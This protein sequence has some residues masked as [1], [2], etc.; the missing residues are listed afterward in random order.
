MEKSF[1]NFFE[2][3]E[4]NWPILAGLL[5]LKFVFVTLHEAT[6]IRIR[7]LVSMLQSM[8]ED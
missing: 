6:E 5:I 1:F 7:D 2:K 3:P 4:I 8:E